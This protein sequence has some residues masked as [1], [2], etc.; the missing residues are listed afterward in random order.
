MDMREPEIGAA[1]GVVFFFFQNLE[2][3]MFAGVQRRKVGGH[4][5]CKSV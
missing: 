1:E 5:Y 3:K 4:R 2:L